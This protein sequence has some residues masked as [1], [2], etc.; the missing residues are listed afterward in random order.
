MLG[1]YMQL[2]L[3]NRSLTTGEINLL[4][5]LLDKINPKYSK[6]NISFP[7]CV[8]TLDDGGMGSFSFFYD[9]GFQNTLEI[10]PISEYQF[11]DRDGIPVLATLYSYSNGQLYELDI[12]KTDF[13]PLLSYPNEI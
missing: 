9:K 8:I 1:E 10:I 4:R 2:K 13:S 3:H 5:I 6:L 11:Q 12:W 7:N